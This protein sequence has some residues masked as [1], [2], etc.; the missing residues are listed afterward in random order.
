M[1]VVTTERSH[2]WP[3]GRVPFEV[4]NDAFPDG[5]LMREAVLD[6]IAEWNNKTPLRLLPRNP[7]TDSDFIVFREFS[8]GGQS[9]IGRQGGEQVVEVDIGSSNQRLIPDQKS[10]AAPALA[11]LLNRLHMVH[12]GDTSNV[13]WHS[14][15]NGTSWTDN[16]RT[17]HRSKT[18]PALAAFQGMLHMVHLDDNSNELRHATSPDGINWQDLGII[19]NQKSKAAPAL[20]VF[21]NALHMVHLGDTSNRIWR[22]VFDPMTATWSQNVVIANHRSK[23]SPALSAF[24]GRLHMVHLDNNSN[25][26]RHATSTDGVDWQDLGIIANQKS[27]AAPALAAHNDGAANATLHMVHLGNSSNDIWHSVFGNGM[28]S[29]NTRIADEKSKASPALAEFMGRVHMVHLGDVSNDIWHSR[30]DEGARAMRIVIHELGHAIGLFHEQSREDR[31]NFVNID[32]DN[33]RDGQEHNFDR[34]VEDADDSGLYDYDS[35]MHYSASSFTKDSSKPAITQGQA[36]TGFLG[37]FANIGT[38]PTLSNGDIETVRAFYPPWTP[39]LPVPDQKSKASPALATLGG[40]LHMV[41]LGDSSN[42]I[43]HSI[44]DPAAGGWNENVAIPNQKSKAAPA[45]AADGSLVHMVH[46]GDSSNDIWHSMFDPAAGGWT[47]NRKI[48]GQKSKA[49]PALAFFQGRV[50][51]V[52]LGNSSNDIWHS[53]FDGME[54]SENTPVLNQQSKAAPALAVFDGRLH[55]VHLGDSSN[56]IWHST[57]DGG[58]WTENV[59]IRNQQSKASP[60]LAVLQNRLHMV[61]LGD[62]SNRLWHSIY[63]GRWRPNVDIEG[64]LSKAPAGL[65]GLGSQLHIVHL[66]NTSNT[67]WHSQH[68]P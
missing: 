58:S 29:A 18:T 4:D 45:L 66:G 32:E 3:N 39:N 27:K 7:D 54:W 25:N 14:A 35:I 61:H 65:A 30:I 55:M 8:L 41:H 59:P 50:H 42:R 28:W 1:G 31:G 22:S 68:M 52:H 20:A 49:P 53:S 56:D 43:W 9:P 46:L 37:S 11:R 64:Q 44:F 33:I 34:E 60:A 13:I 21:L 5:S 40:A 57:Y 51:M 2:R 26:L 10:K 67:I 16:N 38:L 6:A 36:T 17:P 47:D 62:S 15:F 48:P 12:L 24:L 19:P 63:D 23:A